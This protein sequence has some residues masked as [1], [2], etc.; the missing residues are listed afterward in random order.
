MCRRGR[1]GY[2]LYVVRVEDRE[3]LQRDLAAR[4]CHRHH[5]PIG[6]APGEGRRGARLPP[7]DFP[8]AD[9]RPRRFS[10]A[11]D[12]SLLTFEQQERVAPV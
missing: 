11:P 2:H 8:L 1:V 7:G 3:R 5:Y 9:R 10:F 4:H 6:V 12:V